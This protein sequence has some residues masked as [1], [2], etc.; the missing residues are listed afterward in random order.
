MGPQ[1][2]AWIGLFEV[3]SESKGTVYELRIYCA[4]ELLSTFNIAADAAMPTCASWPLLPAFPQWK[5]S[6]VWLG[7]GSAVWG[8]ALDK[9]QLELVPEVITSPIS[10]EVT[11]VK[12]DSTWLTVGTAT[13]SIA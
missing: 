13:G 4:G 1:H 5:S 3:A 2:D 7:I 12:A 9:Q 11:A 6:L 8:I 10:G